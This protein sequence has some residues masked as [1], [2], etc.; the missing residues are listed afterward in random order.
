MPYKPEFL[1][2][3]T[4]TI[5]LPLDKANEQ[6]ALKSIMKDLVAL[7]MGR[8]HRA[9]GIEGVK[10]KTS[11]LPNKQTCISDGLRQMATRRVRRATDPSCYG[12]PSSG[13]KRSI[14]M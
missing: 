12:G 11:S 1:G 7:Q 8:R 6:E 2:D 4:R 9:P 14:T 13:K 10:T 5:F 3:M